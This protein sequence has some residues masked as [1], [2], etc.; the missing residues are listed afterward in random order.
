M[1]STIFPKPGVPINPVGTR[2]EASLHGEILLRLRDYVVEGKHSR[3]RPRFPNDKLLRDGLASPETP[4]REAL[5]VLAAEGLIELLPNRGRTRCASLA[6]PGIWRSFSTSWAGLE[7]LAG[8]PCLRG[9]HGR[10]NRRDRAAA[11]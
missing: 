8:T 10:G 6:W 1:K 7:S 11:L 3:G 4:L 9:H 2:Q 5:K